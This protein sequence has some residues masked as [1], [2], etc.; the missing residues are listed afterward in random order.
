MF[1]RYG[2]PTIIEID[3]FQGHSNRYQTR[4]DER[5]TEDI[6]ALWGDNIAF[7]R[8]IFKELKISTDQEIA[9]ELGIE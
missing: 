2:A 9:K 6:Q 5:R 7:R 8:Y 1:N 3:G 4:R